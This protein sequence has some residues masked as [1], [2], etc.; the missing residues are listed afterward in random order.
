MNSIDFEIL[1][2]SSYDPEK[3]IILAYIDIGNL[4]PKRAKQYLETIKEKMGPKFDERGFDV[5]YIGRN[6]NGVTSTA[7]K[8]SSKE[9]SREIFDDALKVVE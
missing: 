4:P 3:D 6:R 8:V 5:I 9:N 7:I 1:N 2:L